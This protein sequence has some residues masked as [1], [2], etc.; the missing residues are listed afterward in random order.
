MKSLNLNIRDFFFSNDCIFC[1]EK[2]QE[3]YRY[4][5]H[6]CYKNLER[7]RSLRNVGNFYY[8]FDYDRDIKRLIG[9]FKL[10]NR[11]YISQIFGDLTGKYLRE[12]ISFEK[13]DMVIPVPISIKRKRERGFNQVEDILEYLKIPYESVRRVKN[14]LPMHQLLDEELR[15][16]NIK[17]SFASSLEVKGKTILVIDD[18]V[19]TGSTVREL[20]KILKSCGEPKKIVVFSL[21]AA[22]TAVNNKVSF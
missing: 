19:T 6:E 22:K 7:K 14:T 5:C 2:S 21:A 10:K 13:V 12:I 15:K 11:R 17:N 1:S 18:I 8:I 16:E 3:K 9:F 4:L 20:T